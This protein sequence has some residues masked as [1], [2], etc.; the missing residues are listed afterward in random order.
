MVIAAVGSLWTT[1]KRIHGENH[2]NFAPVKEVALL[3]VGI[4]ATMVPAL[5]YLYVHA[6]DAGF[7]EYLRTPGQYFFMTGSLSSVLDNAPTYMTYLESEIGKIDPVLVERAKA[8]IDAPG[9]LQAG[10]DDFAGL[11]PGQREE[12][13]HAVSAVRAVQGAGEA[14][15]HGGHVRED[16]V[17]VAFLLEDPRK[18]LYLM[19][20]SLGAVFFGA[21][22][23]IGNGPNFMV[24]SI[25]EHAG[26]PCASF[27]SYIFYYTLPVLLPVFILIW[28][29]FFRVSI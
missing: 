28:A 17:H 21:C 8:I 7:K 3:F 26:A 13:A 6:G 20:I 2:F 19:A 4:F 27:F 23:Y 16:A 11:N 24:K 14:A 25:A 15:G 1:P 10:E 29:L 9:N 22:T 5:N 12:L 18:A